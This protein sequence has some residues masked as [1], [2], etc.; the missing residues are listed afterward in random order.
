[1]ITLCAASQAC[2]SQRVTPREHP[3]E[4]CTRSLDCSPLA[5]GRA[6]LSTFAASLHSQAVPGAGRAATPPRCWPSRA[7]RRRCWRT[8]RPRGTRSSR[9][10]SSRR[11]RRARAQ[12]RPYQR[13]TCRP[14]SA[15]PV[16]SSV[17]LGLGAP[18]RAAAACRPSVP[19]VCA[20]G[21]PARVRAERRAA[22]R[23]GGRRG[24]AGA[25]APADAP[26]AYAAA[27]ALRCGA[28]G[29]A[30]RRGAAE[31]RP[32]DD[33]PQ[34][35]AAQGDRKAHGAPPAARPRPLRG[36]GSARRRM[37][38][39][40]RGRAGHRADQAVVRQA[41]ARPDAEGVPAAQDRG[42]QGA[43]RCLPRARAHA[44]VARARARPPARPQRAPPS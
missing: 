37:L 43:P 30:G 7:W 19:A 12:A 11:W 34:Q 8:R 35:G 33:V 32:R 40:G 36:P 23:R 4:L 15:C 39:A 10:S 9:R 44:G 18:P 13:H 31:R 3:S 29:R 22:A 41:Q 26:P 14:R 2:C 38:S 21:R 25:D 17:L 28:A 42:R 20:P 1:M 27:A 6:P 16:A 5:I 24:A